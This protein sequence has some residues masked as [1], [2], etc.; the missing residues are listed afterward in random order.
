MNNFFKLV[1][2][3]IPENVFIVASCNPHRGDS[4]ATHA[5]DKSWLKTTYYVQKL[6]PT[7][8][9]LICDYGALDEDQERQ[10]I[11]AKLEM[12]NENNFR[13]LNNPELTEL[14]LK[15]QQKMREYAAEHLIKLGSMKQ[16]ANTHARSTVSQRDIQRVFTFYCWLLKLYRKPERR[17]QCTSS[18]QRRAVMVA[19]G[20]V[21]YMR[22]NETYRLRYTTYIDEEMISSEHD[23]SFKDALDEELNWFINNVNPPPGIA[24]TTALKENV[25]A[26]IACTV[27]CTPLIIVGDPGSS[28]TLSFNLVVSKLK[29]KETDSQSVFQHT[30]I[31]QALDPHFYQCSRRTTSNEVQKVFTRAIN[32]QHTFSGIS[33][34]MVCVVF[35]DEAGL[36]EEQ[37]ESLKVLHQYLDQ[38]N[39]SFVAISNDIL[40]A[41]KTNRAVSL[42]RPKAND[43]ELMELAKCAITTEQRKLS[44]VEEQLIQAL[45]KSYKC[46]LALDLTMRQMFGL[47]D[48]MYFITYLRRN[49]SD[50]QGM[51]PQLV[52]ESLE[53]NFSGTERF[54]EIC[55]LFFNNVS[56]N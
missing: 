45:C 4:L 1:L 19:L 2:Q 3:P 17:F 48:F 31:F 43:D 21:Y 51:T 46:T 20:L 23:I 7:L 56:I 39:V 8:Q 47:R 49:C 33:L 55:D 44:I 5:E 40:D 32:R 41:A 26:I 34:N 37:L 16:V 22:L 11:N 29:G 12:L 6:H 28:K 54:D 9:Y 35:M 30:D 36:P 53:R 50:S 42:F 27:T 52:L 10:Y 14:I 25:F 15:S 13:D 24:K 38:P 18:Q